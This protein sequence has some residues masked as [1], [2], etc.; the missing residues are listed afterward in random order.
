M[1]AVLQALLC[2]DSAGAK[3]SESNV[4]PSTTYV[5]WYSYLRMGRRNRNLDQHTSNN[6]LNRKKAEV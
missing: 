3:S 4:I 2:S 5:P 6:N 1:A